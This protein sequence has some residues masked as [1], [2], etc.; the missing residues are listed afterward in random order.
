[1]QQVNLFEVPARLPLFEN[2][3]HQS[4]FQRATNAFDVVGPVPL[5]AGLPGVNGLFFFA[6]HFGDRADPQA[7]PIQEFGL[8]AIVTDG[9]GFSGS[10]GGDAAAARA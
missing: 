5:V 10:H 4:R 6:Q 3:L 9:G 2:E 8:A 7:G 1:M